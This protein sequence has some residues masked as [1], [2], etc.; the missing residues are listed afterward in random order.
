MKEIYLGSEEDQRYIK[1]YLANIRQLDPIEIATLPNPITLADPLLG[2]VINLD[3]FRR[4]VNSALDECEKRYGV[5]LESLEPER[6]YTSQPTEDNDMGGFYSPYSLGYQYWYHG[7]FAVTLNKRIASKELRTLEFI[8]DFLHDCFHFS[9]FVSFR[10]VIRTPAKSPAAAKHCVPEVYREQ[11]GINFR[12][13]EGLSY[14]STTLTAYSPETINLNLLMDG[15]IV[16]TVAELMKETSGNV[17]NG[18]TALEEEIR[19]E[20]FLEPFDIA[21]LSRAHGFHNAVTDP[22]RLFVNHWGGASFVTLVLQAMMNGDLQPLKN[23]F[24]EKVGMPNAWEKKFRR[25]GFSIAAN[26]RF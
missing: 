18:A 19:K 23:F 25:P 10:R 7:A 26:P 13:E 11:Y 17:A 15:V 12:N 1:T 2:E 4:T 8:R 22:S 14:S 9:T 3:R 20:I 16:L 5:R 6:Y 21:M 24:K